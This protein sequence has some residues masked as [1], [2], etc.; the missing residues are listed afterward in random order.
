MSKDQNSP[1]VNEFLEIIQIPCDLCG[2][3]Y[4]DGF[5]ENGSEE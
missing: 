1:E 5:C 3:V 2:D 4:C